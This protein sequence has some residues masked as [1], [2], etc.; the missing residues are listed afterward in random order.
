MRTFLTRCA[1]VALAAAVATVNVPA[2]A[3]EPQDRDPDK[4][5]TGGGGIPAGW[6]ARLDSGST[7]AEGVRFMVMGTGVHFMTGP[8]GIYWKPDMTKSG[9]YEVT[10]TFN[11][12]EPTDHPEAY[13]LFIG[14][15]NLTGAGQ[16]YT[17][18]LI[19]QDGKYL[20]KRRAGANTPT[21][22]DWT[23]SPA[24]KKTSAGTRGV[25]TLTVAVTADKVRFSI[26]GT[27]VSAVA[28]NQVDASGIAGLRINHN[29]NVHVEGLGVK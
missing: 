21:I 20:I 25:N 19:R 14:G 9:T 26:N 16:K 4:A 29:L 13:G 11:Q 8:A 18:F 5:A 10:A 3:A 28:P 7:R 17:Y 2:Q 27:E 1:A 6:L 22:A 15:T 23:D 24:V 12:M